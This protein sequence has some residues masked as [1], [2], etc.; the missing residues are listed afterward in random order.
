MS[1]ELANAIAK[2][3]LAR[4]DV[5]AIQYSN[6]AYSP[7]REPWT[8][9]DLDSHLAGT[10]TFGHYLINP[11]DRCKL[12]CFDVDLEKDGVLPWDPECNTWFTVTEEKDADGNIIPTSGLRGAWHDRAHPGRTWMKTQFK[13]IANILATGV[14]DHLG[15]DVAV[16]YSGNKGIHVYGFFGKEIDSDAAREGAMIVLDS[17]GEFH[18]HRGQVF[19]KHNDDNYITGFPNLTVEVYPKQDSIANK[20]LGNLLRLPLGRNQKSP[21]DPTFFVD[22]ST[23]ADQFGPVDALKAMSPGYDAWTA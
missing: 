4:R 10:R 15:I 5:K 23:G 13:L 20:D 9:E 17:I 22:M 2:R 21:Q 18:A 7:I 6:G 3:F 19:F 11:E 8:R 12:F 14:K 16:A 1:E